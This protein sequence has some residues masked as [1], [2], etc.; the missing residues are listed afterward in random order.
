M[1]DGGQQRVS[2]KATVRIEDRRQLAFPIDALLEALLALDHQRHGWLWRAVSPKLLIEG[3]EPKSVVVEALRLAT[4]DPERVEFDVRHVAAAIIH[5][6]WLEHVPVPRNARKE[7]RLTT[8]GA[9]LLLSQTIT[10]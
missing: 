1:S 4:S 3:T 9:V 7:V 10:I 6:C 2:P 8:E 5:Y